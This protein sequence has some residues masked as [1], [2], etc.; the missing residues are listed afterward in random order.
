MTEQE[1]QVFSQ[2]FAL[3]EALNQMSSMALDSNPALTN[4]LNQLG[5]NLHTTLQDSQSRLQGNQ[6]LYN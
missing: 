5:Y 1:K 3:N 4:I 2:A 6:P